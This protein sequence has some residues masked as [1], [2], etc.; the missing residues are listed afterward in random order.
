MTFAEVTLDGDLNA[1]ASEALTFVLLLGGILFFLGYI[2]L[3]QTPVS[4]SSSPRQAFLPR[5]DSLS[6]PSP[7]QASSQKRSGRRR[8]L[9][10]PGR[11]GDP[12]EKRGSLRRGGNTVPVAVTFAESQAEPVEGNVLD[13]SRGGLRL[14]LRQPVEVGKLL[15]VRAPHFPDDLASVRIRVRH[16]QQRGESWLLGCQFVDE[17]PWSI[18]LMFG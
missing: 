3:G 9:G 2:V 18:L 12:R 16:C 15:A 4:S 14:A 13:R 17:L 10:I 6:M 8:R 1:Y 5:Q 7:D 11:R